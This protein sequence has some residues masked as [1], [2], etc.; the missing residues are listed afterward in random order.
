M[1]KCKNC[2]ICKMAKTT[3]SKELHNFIMDKISLKAKYYLAFSALADF[4][5]GEEANSRMYD[6]HENQ[7]NDEPLLWALEILSKCGKKG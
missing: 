3:V 5:V 4:L 2:W 6:N 1:K 7:Y